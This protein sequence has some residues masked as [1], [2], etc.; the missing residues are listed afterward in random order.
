MS[1]S[2]SKAGG[3]TGTVSSGSKAT[4]GAA[5]DN[6]DNASNISA[7]TTKHSSDL[8]QQQQEEELPQEGEDSPKD[9]APVDRFH[10][11]VCIQISEAAFFIEPSTGERRLLS[12]GGY[13]SIAAVWGKDNYWLARDQE[14]KE[15]NNLDLG[16]EE[17]W[18]KLVRD[19][20]EFHGGGGKRLLTPL[21]AW[22]DDLRVPEDADELLYRSELFRALIW[23]IT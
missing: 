3:G 22:V 16:N 10:A 15:G 18:I 11:W 7:A 14:W 1:V 6:A 17:H 5:A 9:G 23:D 12:D 20:G 8:Q 21:T 4:A 19:D 2:G 13:I